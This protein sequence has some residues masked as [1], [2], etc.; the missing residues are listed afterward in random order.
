MKILNAIAIAGISLSSLILAPVTA[1][2]QTPTET[3]VPNTAATSNDWKDFANI[4]TG[5]MQGCMGKQALPAAQKKIKQDFCQ[6]A[7]VSYKNRYSPQVFMQMNALAVKIGQ[8][9]P[10]LVS[11]MMK[12][13]LDSCFERTG[14]RP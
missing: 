6:C 14:Y 7:F 3:P 5:F 9:G 10:A 8:D 2:S 4:E 12:P 11:V 13:E 1:Q